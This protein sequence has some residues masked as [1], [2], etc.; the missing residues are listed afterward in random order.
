MQTENEKKHTQNRGE[1]KWN[2]QD[3]EWITSDDMLNVQQQQQQLIPN[4][5]K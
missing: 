2:G 5:L 4:R 3:G 1:L